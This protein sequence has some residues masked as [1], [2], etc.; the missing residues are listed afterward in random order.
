MYMLELFFG[1]MK[2]EEVIATL[3]FVKGGEYTLM[4]WLGQVLAFIVPMVLVCLALKKE[5]YY[6]LKIAAVSALIGLWIAKHVWLVI[7]QLLNMS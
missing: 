2:A 1:P 3:E 4:F 6:L 5:S 7:P